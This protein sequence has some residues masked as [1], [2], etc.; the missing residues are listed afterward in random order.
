MSSYTQLDEAQIIRTIEQLRDRIA[1][2][3]PQSNLRRV[4]EQLLQATRDVSGCV[5]FLRRPNW[6]VRIFGGVAIVAL[7]ALLIA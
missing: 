3:F 2:R 7:T 1:E 6:K 5:A 4:C